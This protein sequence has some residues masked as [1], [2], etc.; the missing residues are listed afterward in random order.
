[1]HRIDQLTA[2]IR[3][4]AVHKSCRGQSVGSMLLSSLEQAALEMGMSTVVLHSR[5]SAYHFYIKNG[6]TLGE[7]SHVLYGE[8]VHFYMHKKL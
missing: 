8:I 5:E 2:Q 6:Y 4:M 1:M 7:R 3:Y